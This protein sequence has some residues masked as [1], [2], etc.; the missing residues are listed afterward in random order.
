MGKVLVEVQ[1]LLLVLVEIHVQLGSI[2]QA[3]ADTIGLEKLGARSN[4]ATGRLVEGSFGKWM[5]SL[6]KKTEAKV[7]QIHVSLW[8]LLGPATL[9]C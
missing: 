9:S 1:K 3:N 8:Q 2:V 6:L 5:H 4:L 7:P